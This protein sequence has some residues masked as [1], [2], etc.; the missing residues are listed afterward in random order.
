MFVPHKT[1]N[2]GN[3]YH[4]IAC[5]KSKVIYNIDIMEGKDRTKGMGKKDFEE[6][7]GGGWFDGEDEK[8]VMGYR[9]GGG[10]GK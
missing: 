10:H 7:G 5:A 3:E 1:Q 8:A 4:T 6:K 2:F 9:E